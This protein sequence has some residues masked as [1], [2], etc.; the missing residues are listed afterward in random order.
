MT[1]R[2]KGRRVTVRSV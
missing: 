1:G 2:Y